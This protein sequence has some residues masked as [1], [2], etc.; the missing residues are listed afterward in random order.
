LI[1]VTAAQPQAG[2][3]AGP[4]HSSLLC[5]LFLFIIAHCELES[6]LAPSLANGLS[7]F[8]VVG[9]RILNLMAGLSE[10]RAS[11]ESRMTQATVLGYCQPMDIPR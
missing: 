5:F 2:Q 3:Q 10:W 8:L 9:W 7:F 11:N 1:I 4:A 6:L